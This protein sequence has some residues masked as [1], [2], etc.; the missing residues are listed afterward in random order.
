MRSSKGDKAPTP[1]ALGSR[2]STFNPLELE[3][4][5]KSL[6]QFSDA[7]FQKPKGAK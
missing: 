5:P 3:K 6:D 4:L 2:L 1:K 7:G